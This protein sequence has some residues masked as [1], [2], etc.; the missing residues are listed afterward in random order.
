MVTVKKVLDAIQK[1]IES[2][3]KDDISIIG[4]QNR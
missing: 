4:L 1:Q 3:G 2:Y